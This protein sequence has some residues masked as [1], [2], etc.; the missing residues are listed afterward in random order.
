[1]T[2]LKKIF[3]KPLYSALR[4]FYIIFGQNH[5]R[6]WFFFF[7][8]KSIWKIMKY[9]RWYPAQAGE[10]TLI[11]INMIRCLIY[12]LLP[13]A[14]CTV[15]E[16]FLTLLFLTYSIKLKSKCNWIF[17]RAGNDKNLNRNWLHYNYIH[18]FPM[19]LLLQMT[20]RNCIFVFFI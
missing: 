9:T 15:S 13:F 14:V 20:W 6:K 12:I 5:A 3:Y 16:I 18:S 19:F 4:Q 2:S 8:R 10:L 11:H 1:M 17:R 7:F